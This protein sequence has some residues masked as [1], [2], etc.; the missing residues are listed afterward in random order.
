MKKY[1]EKKVSDAPQ[2]YVSCDSFDEVVSFSGRKLSHKPERN[3][4]TTSFLQKLVMYIPASAGRV[5]Q[6]RATP[7]LFHI[8]CTNEG[9]TQCAILVLVQFS[10]LR[11]SLCRD[12]SSNCTKIHISKGCSKWRL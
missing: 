7:R 8:I 5:F 4:Y 3:S 12:A 11:L 9:L 10:K 1:N 6:L 2:R